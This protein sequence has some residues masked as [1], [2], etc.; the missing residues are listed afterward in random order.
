MKMQKYQEQ[1]THQK[2]II[3]LFAVIANAITDNQYIL[4]E[5]ET[6]ERAMEIINEIAKTYVLTEQYKV[7]DE[8]T[9]IKLMMEGVLLYEMPKEQ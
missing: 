2:I 3:G 6:K 4:G 9:R 1:V 7:E 5:Y 8:R